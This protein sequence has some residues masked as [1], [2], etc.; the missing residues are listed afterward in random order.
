MSHFDQ[1]TVHVY[2]RDYVDRF[3]GG[4]KHV[5]AEAL[6]CSIDHLNGLMQPPRVE[7]RVLPGPELAKRLG[8]RRIVVYEKV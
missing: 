4:D 3:F 6:K 8:L 7:R 2:V 1:E 5:A